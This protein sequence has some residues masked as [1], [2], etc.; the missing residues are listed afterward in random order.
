VETYESKD[1]LSLSYFSNYPNTSTYD[2]SGPNINYNISS[3]C[4]VSSVGFVVGLNPN[5]MDY[6][7]LVGSQIKHCILFCHDPSLTFVLQDDSSI[8]HHNSQS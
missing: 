8:S 4:F 1:F 3:R 5:N 2:N 7:G 6:G